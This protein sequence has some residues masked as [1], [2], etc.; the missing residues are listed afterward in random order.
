MSRNQTGILDIS[1]GHRL[2]AGAFVAGI[3]LVA[4]FAMVAKTMMSVAV[5]I[6]VVIMSVIYLLFG[7]R[8]PHK[9]FTRL[10]P[11]Y[12]C[13]LSIQLLHF[14]E[15]YLTGFTEKLPALLGQ[16][17]YPEEYWIIFNM[18]AYAIF[19]AGALIIYF[20]I[21]ILYVIPVFFVFA[22]VM[23]NPVIHLLLALNVGGY[24]PGLY[25]SILY[26]IFMPFVMRAF[27][28]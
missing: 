2:V 5:F 21:Q 13:A 4:S 3:V 28:A 6:P 17:P 19:I 11:Y 8:S 14:T 25:T 9:R 22:A 26:I 7:F 24:F 12:L 27:L 23:L 18:V 10:L 16:D 15:E 20:R 1:E